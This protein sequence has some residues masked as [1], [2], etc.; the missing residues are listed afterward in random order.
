MYLTTDE[1]NELEK[2]LLQASEIGYGKTRCESYLKENERIKCPS[3]SDGWWTKF[4]QRHPNVRLRSGDATA[5]VRM[6]AVNTENLC[7]YYEE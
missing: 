5:G 6:D 1:Q 3:L 7:T 2:Y 4:L